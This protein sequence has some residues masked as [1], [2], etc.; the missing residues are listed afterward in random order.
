V[1][2]RRDLYLVAISI[3]FWGMGESLF[4]IFQPLY[5]QELGASSILIGTILGINSI[6]MGILQIPLG[7][8]SDRYGRRSMMWM[9]WCL[10]IVAAVIMG[11][12]HNLT[13]FV[14]GF[15][16]YGLTA[17]VIAPMNSYLAS[18]RGDWSVGKAISFISAMYSAGALIGP[19]IGGILADRYGIPVLY[20]LAALIF[21]VST[22]IIFFIREQP[23]E[24]KN[25]LEG[26][27][28]LLKN[29][30][31][32][33]ALGIVF[34]VM[35]AMYLPYPLNSNFLQ[36]ERGLTMTSIG[37]LGTTA[38][39]ATVIFIFVLGHI[40]PALAFIIGQ[41]A[42]M[43]FSL[44]IWKGTGLP[45]YILAYFLI[46]GFRLS[47][48]LRSAFVRPFVGAH[49]VGLAF[50]FGE[51]VS[52]LS[53]V[54]A[55]ILAGFIYEQNPESVYPISIAILGISLVLSILVIRFKADLKKRFLKVPPVA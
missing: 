22:V 41:V 20:K 25:E 17:A 10:G 26:D 45:W 12:A 7:Y 54:I 39:V 19:T 13:V 3:L 11:F 30:R 14:I 47:A 37:I 24:K 46:G 16:M 2:Q 43:S 23:I 33:L 50:G 29:T 6:G 52:N 15:L 44:L 35:F 40:Q 4:F 8:I 18:A 49:Q 21:I 9:S 5:I 51:A 36:N 42:M 48:S 27:R 34:V 53:F 55:P 38:S 32:I 31:F 1:K 28:R